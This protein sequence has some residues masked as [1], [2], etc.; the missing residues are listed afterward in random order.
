M[1]TLLDTPDYFNKT[2]PGAASGLVKDDAIQAPYTYYEVAQSYIWNSGTTILPVAGP[3]PKG[4]SIPAEVVQL[5]SPYGFKVVDWACRRRGDMPL[6][7][8]MAAP[9]DNHVLAYWQITTHAPG[10][11]GDM[12][13]PIIRAEGKYVYQLLLAPS[14]QD[15][16]LQMGGKPFLNVVASGCVFTAADFSKA[17]LAT[18]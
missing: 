18:S 5:S 1:T 8:D 3:F 9:D 12:A 7:P 15:G 13:S 11:S 17:I 14:I 4:G 2:S 10:L 16:K 6:L